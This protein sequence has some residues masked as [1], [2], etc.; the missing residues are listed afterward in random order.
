MIPQIWFVKKTIINAI[1]F[2]SVQTIYIIK[3]WGKVPQNL[4][5]VPKSFTLAKRWESY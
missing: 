5:K 2:L 1:I 3:F 4:G